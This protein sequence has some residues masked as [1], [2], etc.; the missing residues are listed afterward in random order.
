M[1]SGWALADEAISFLGE[2]AG[3][4][5]ELQALKGRRPSGAGAG[6]RISNHQMYVCN[7]HLN[8]YLSR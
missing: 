8:E 1:Y 4:R 2:A 7:R 5:G 6:E 3:L